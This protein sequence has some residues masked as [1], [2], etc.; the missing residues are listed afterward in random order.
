MCIHVEDMFL[1]FFSKGAL[2]KKLDKLGSLL[3]C[4]LTDKVLCGVA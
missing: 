2:L 1:L 4:G 3:H